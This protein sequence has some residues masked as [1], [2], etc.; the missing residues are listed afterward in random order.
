MDVYLEDSKQNGTR[1]Q[2]SYLENPIDG[3]AW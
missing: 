1:L 3:G 2:Y